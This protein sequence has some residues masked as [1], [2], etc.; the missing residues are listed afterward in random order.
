MTGPTWDSEPGIHDPA[1]QPVTDALTRYAEEAAAPPPAGLAEQIRGALASEPLPRRG[2]LAGFLPQGG[3]QLRRG[4]GLAAAGVL[5]GA[6]VVIALVGGQ[7]AELLRDVNAGSSASPAP[8]VMA[9]PIPSALPSPSP[10]PS[11]SPEPPPSVVPSATPQAET[12]A[13][14]FLPTPTESE[15]EGGDHSGPGGGDETPGPTGESGE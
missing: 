1:L 3:A 6:A 9:S 14:S 12:Q 7:L 13:P 8:I 15:D 10:S 2:W 11:P 5:M 4:I